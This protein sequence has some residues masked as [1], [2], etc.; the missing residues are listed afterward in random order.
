MIPIK[1]IKKFMENAPI[2]PTRLKD[3]RYY[4]GCTLPTG[5]DIWA[6]AI[7]VEKNMSKKKNLK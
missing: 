5:E 4:Y 7:E 2:K 6:P 3:G 1:E